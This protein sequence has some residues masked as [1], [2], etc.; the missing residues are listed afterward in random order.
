[1]QQLAASWREHAWHQENSRFADKIEGVSDACERDLEGAPHLKGQGPCPAQGQGALEGCKDQ[2]APPQELLTMEH[3]YLHSL[4]Q[5]AGLES[6][7]PQPQ[8]LQV[9]E[10]GPQRGH[11]LHIESHVVHL[12]PQPKVGGCWSCCRLLHVCKAAK[13]GQR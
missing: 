8:P 3:S 7:P 2:G 5:A 11:C 4:H 13:Q 1:L 6:A 10:E 12:Q 9:G